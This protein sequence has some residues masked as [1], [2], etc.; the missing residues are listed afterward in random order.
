MSGKQKLWL[1]VV[2]AVTA[3][4]LG[5]LF[6]NSP[7]AHIQLAAETVGNDIFGKWNI[8]NSLIAAWCAVAVVI[9][10]AILATRKMQIVPRNRFQNLVEAFIG[11]LADLTESMAG[12]KW[13]P[14]FL[15]LIA[16][17]FIFILVANWSALLPVFGTI[18][19]VEP[20][21][22]I[23]AHELRDVV[24]DVNDAAKKRDPGAV[25]YV[26]VKK[27]DAHGHEEMPYEKPAPN[28]VAAF[29]REVGNDRLVIFDGEEGTRLIPIGFKKIKEMRISEYWDFD[30]WEARHGEVEIK[31]GDNLETLNI[32]GKT[33]GR[34]LPYLR[35]MNTD[36]MNTLAL[37]L[38]AMFLIEYWG[39]KANGFG[40]YASRFINFKQGPIGFAVG[41]LEIISEFARIISFSFRLLGN[42][43]AGEILLFSSLFLLPVMAGVVILPFFMETAVGMIQALVFSVLALVFGSMA[44]TSHEEHGEAH[45]HEYAEGQAGHQAQSPKSGGHTEAVIKS[46]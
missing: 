41:L 44:V 32:D 38:V 12:R 45:G 42:M 19:K 39:I 24:K 2:L 35:S 33:P 16:T 3:S 4:V 40:S 7:I 9:I 31:V 29:Q 14:T 43:F 6:L 8:T 27:A 11:W 25:E 22:E 30:H 13:G 28:I 36:L 5:R 26:L 15:P 21:Q 18:G 17:L 37:A 46:T 20:A 1:I 34:L 23:L 10:L